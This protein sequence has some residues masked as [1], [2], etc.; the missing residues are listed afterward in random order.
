MNLRAKSL[1]EDSKLVIVLFIIKFKD[2]AAD[3]EWSIW[4]KKN[5]VWF[6][7]G[8]FMLVYIFLKIYWV[9]IQYNIYITLFK[10]LKI[11]IVWFIP[12]ILPLSVWFNS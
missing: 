3:L 8:G 6:I 5:S 11:N 4:F 10:S 12:K 1:K 9:I 7:V 2:K